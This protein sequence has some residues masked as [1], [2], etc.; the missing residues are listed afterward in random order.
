MYL[1][2]TEAQAG[3]N[4]WVKIITADVLPKKLV[5]VSTST[6]KKIYDFI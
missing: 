6:I 5:D 2:K 4:K 1:T 3:H